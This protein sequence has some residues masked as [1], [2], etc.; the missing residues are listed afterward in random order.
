M[1][2]ADDISKKAEAAASSAAD[3]AADAAGGLADSFND[4]R[5]GERF[6]GLVRAYNEVE[7]KGTPLRPYIRAARESLNDNLGVVKVGG[8]VGWVGACVCAD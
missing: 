3:A 5:L 7:E 1:P 2:A 4:L 6:T 8:W